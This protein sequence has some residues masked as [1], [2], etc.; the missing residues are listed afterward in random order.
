MHNNHQAMVMRVVFD[1]GSPF[2]S[3]LNTGPAQVKTGFVFLF[4][5]L[6]F[7]LLKYKTINILPKKVDKMCHVLSFL[8]SLFVMMMIM[9]IVVW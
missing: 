6:L 4:Q 2:C 8:L 9:M 5:G 1:L 3:T 7:G